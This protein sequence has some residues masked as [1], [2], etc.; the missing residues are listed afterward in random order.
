LETLANAT[1]HL[2]LKHLNLETI[3]NLQHTTHTFQVVL[4]KKVFFFQKKLLFF[5]KTVFSPISAHFMRV[6]RKAFQ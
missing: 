4:R 6:S 1:Q 3:S 5:V 2:P